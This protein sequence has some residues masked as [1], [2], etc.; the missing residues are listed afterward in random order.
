[1][2]GVDSWVSI[3][4]LDASV[5][6]VLY[7]TQKL[8]VLILNNNAVVVQLLKNQFLLCF[9]S[10]FFRYTEPVIHVLDASRS[11][12]VVRIINKE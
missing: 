9:Y 10:I 2:F 1:M 11:V 4:A 8:S 3:I 7:S 6:E 5:S 12:V